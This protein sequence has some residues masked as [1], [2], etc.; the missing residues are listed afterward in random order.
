[1]LEQMNRECLV[2][3]WYIILYLRIFQEDCWMRLE[4]FVEC[5]L[6]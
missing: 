5:I 6:C 4:F 2:F 1:M 3:S